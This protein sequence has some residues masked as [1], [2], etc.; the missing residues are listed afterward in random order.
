MWWRL[1]GLASLGEVGNLALAEIA[2]AD[3]ADE[4]QIRPLRYRTP[5]AI[6]LL[7]NG[8][9]IESASWRRRAPPRARLARRVVQQ[10]HKRQRKRDDA[11]AR[12]RCAS[13][14]GLVCRRPSKHCRVPCTGMH[15]CEAAAF[16]DS[17]QTQQ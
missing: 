8:G 9:W 16:P 15:I 5:M 4:A 7:G 12:Q 17:L 13:E 2:R 10:Q 6:I 11:S 14:L 3:N 1:L